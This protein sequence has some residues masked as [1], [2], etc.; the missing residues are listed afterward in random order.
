MG[1]QLG[2]EVGAYIAKEHEKH[3]VKLYKERKVTEIKGDGKEAHTV[4]LDDGT[5]IKADL[6]LVGAGVLPATK[7][8]DGSGIKLDQWG[9]VICDPYL[10]SSV[11]DIYAAGDIASYPY[12]LTGQQQRIEH[13]ISAMDQ[14]SYAAFNMLGKL[15][16]FG[17]VPFYWTRHYNKSI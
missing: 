1:R 7:F 3:G 4:V 14:G 15:V 13:Y 8:L 17:N 6:V 9:A 5:E 12:W 16:P 2:T 11:K 10:Q